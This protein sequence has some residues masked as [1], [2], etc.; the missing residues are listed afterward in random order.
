M[1][2]ESP[3]YIQDFVAT[4][5]DGADPKSQGD[6]H[7]RNIKSASKNTF[8]NATHAWYFP[9]STT[10]KTGTVNVVA[11]DAT[12][13]FPCDASGG[14]MT[15]NLPANAT[16][17]DGWECL[18]VKT[19]SSANTVT[20]DGNG[21]DTINGAL[22]LVLTAPYD[23]ARLIWCSGISAW[24]SLRGISAASIAL[25]QIDLHGATQLTA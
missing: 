18:V 13:A 1:G 6:D 12:K 24:I 8:P 5:P 4:N 9:N 19:D 16:L 20:I 21:A 11:A 10:S 25:S 23:V 2:L 15:V 7:I 3:T 17:Y 22:T 14:A